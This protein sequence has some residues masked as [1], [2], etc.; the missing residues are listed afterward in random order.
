MPVSFGWC[1]LSS[2]DI[3]ELEGLQSP[4]TGRAGLAGL[5]WRSD[6]LPGRATM[7]MGLVQS[8]ASGKG[9]SFSPPCRRSGIPLDDVRQRPCVTIVSCTGVAPALREITYRHTDPRPRRRRDS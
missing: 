5:R 7:R 1:M 2:W 6:P 8:A 3:V 4:R 9:P